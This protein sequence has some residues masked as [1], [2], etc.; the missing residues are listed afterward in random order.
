MA[1][2]NE[3]GAGSAPEPKMNYLQKI[4]HFRRYL[5]IEPFFFFYFMA[6]VLNQ[7][8][9]QNF[10]LEKACRVNLGYSKAT[11]TSMLDKSVLGIECD[12]FNFENTTKGASPEQGLLG[13]DGTGFNYTV[14]KAEVEAQ[15][16]SADIS[17]K[18]APIA[19]IF[20]LIVLL[21]AGGWSDRYNKRKPCMI[22]PIVGEALGFTCLLISAIFFDSL[23]VEFGMY[24]EVIVPSL[25][26]GL[27]FCLMAIYSY[28]TIATPEEDRVFRFGI[29]AMFV[30]GAPFLGAF[31]GVLFNTFGYI[32]SF[33]S[34]VVFQIIAIL[35][36][37][38]FIKEIKPAPK[39]PEESTGADLPASQLRG[40]AAD[41]MAYE[42]TNLDELPVNKNV[43]FQLTPHLEPPKVEPPPPPVP[44]RRSLLKELFD[45][46]LVVD[47]LRFPLVKR[48]NNGRFLLIL[49]ILAY[50]LTLGPAT[51]ENDYWYRYTLKKL[52]WN[53]NDFSIYSTISGLA[54]LVGTF[55]G[56]AIL[57]KMLKFSD[58]AIGT[59]SA[60]A[61][62]G[63]RVLF[64]LAT[65]T[66]SFYV[67]T[68]V[69]MFVSLRV[70]AIKT[71]GASI[72]DGDE[73][74]K[75]YSIFGISEP[76]GQFIFPPIYSEIYQS[77][78]DKFPGAI[79]LFGE[80]FYVPNVLVF[81]L[82]YFLIRRRKSKEQKNAV[83]LAQNNEGNGQTNPANG[84]EITS[85]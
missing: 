73:L 39:K 76:I 15:I 84:T 49:L 17:G 3:T 55:I 19:A 48:K 58:P 63:S 71:I 85:L 62:V 45:P 40:H 83:E 72:V 53:G 21:F 65:N 64:S 24:L 20:P 52:N 47:C 6:S 67:A 60:L 43:N 33:A 81:V 36:I 69:D 13:I 9:M 16:L 44:A 50:F 42:A 57:S 28:I 66:T 75:M 38:F 56:T 54:A 12:D 23:P 79:F 34:A 51:G 77:T 32:I 18:R 31:S 5:V 26:G 7:V 30:T 37:V 25:C 82:C 46:T 78:V 22:M 1:K 4:W 29:F 35:Y 11:C 27:T 41:N 70:I 59:L 74:S 80:I 68:A 10:P 61:I 8:A 2:I 14:C